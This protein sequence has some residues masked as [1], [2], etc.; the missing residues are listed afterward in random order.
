MWYNFV[1][2]SRDRLDILHS[3]GYWLRLCH[4][5]CARLPRSTSRP[6]SP[7]R[8][9]R[10][11]RRLGLSLPG[12]RHTR[13]RDGAS[14]SRQPA[15]SGVGR[16]LGRRAPRDVGRAAL[17]R[18]G[19]RSVRAPGGR[20]AQ[21]VGRRAA[22]RGARHRPR[23]VRRMALGPHRAGLDRHRGLRPQLRRRGHVSAAGAGAEGEASGDVLLS[24]AVAGDA[25]PP[26]LSDTRTRLS[27]PHHWS[28][29]WSVVGAAR[30]G[31]HLRLRSTGALLVR[32]VG[33]LRGD[34]RRPCGRGLARTARRL[35]RDHRLRGARA[36]ARRRVPAPRTARFLMGL[37]VAG[38][39]HRTAAVAVRE[40][41]ALEEDKL[42]EILREVLVEG[43]MAEAVIVSTCNRVEVYGVAEVPGEARA[44]VF[45]HL[46]H[47]RG[48]D[49]AAVDACLYTH[50]DRDA[51]SHTFRVAASLDS[52]M[53]GEPQIL[54]QVKDAF[55]LAQA[56]EAVG[57]ALHSLFTHAFAVAKKV[58]TETD[59]GRYAVSVSF[60][61]VELAKKIFDGLS[62]RT[63][64]LV[65][66]GKLGELAAR[67]RAQRGAFPI[68]V[69]NR[70]WSR[71][72]E[73]ARALSG[74]AV[75]FDELTT[76]LA[77][78]DIVITST[79]AHEPV[80]RRDMVVEVLHGRRGRPLFFIDIAVPRNVEESVET[81][82]DVYCYDID[83]LKQ[84]VD[85]N[86][87]E[88]RREAQRA[89]TLVEREVGKFLAR[90][91]D[92]D[93]IPTIVSLR[94]RLESIRLGEVKKT[95]AR[96]VDASPETKDAIDALSSAIVN[97]ILHTPITKL[98]ESSRAG[99]GRSWTEL[100]HELFGLG[101]QG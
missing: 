26:D 93:V 90:L 4:R 52:M 84:V 101:R 18:E 83:D 82:E 85:A 24:P 79:G 72:L 61:A 39:N 29:P 55:A 54:G 87:R 35:L 50:V 25:R 96:L 56:C 78:A 1:R 21:H 92:A 86:L 69:A 89:E 81:L 32:R 64:L 70:T 62:G 8:L 88:R 33:D 3:G 66:A 2:R 34:P 94:E 75:P 53:I 60:A 13:S 95:M 22:A 58:R 73:M 38:M 17:R 43:G 47:Q 48:L 63:V 99:H 5:S 6:D 15:R 46:C 23:A 100:V 57:P 36:H 49:P 14:A 51:V 9:R 80:I 37:F 30:V 98:R 41:L 31:E 12:P 71:A 45:R 20:H 65:G 76:A 91:A 97:K 77:S 27:V 74:T 28:S 19:A 59:V 7:S 68:Y 44:T 67:H 11:A 10:N 16:R 42:R 40:Q